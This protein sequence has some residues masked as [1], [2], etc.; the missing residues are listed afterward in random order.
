MGRVG[1]VGGGLF[2]RTAL[3]LERLLPDAR[4]VIIDHSAAHLSIAERLVGPEVQL[5]NETYEPARHDGFDL[6]VVPLSY[7]GDRERLYVDPP[8]GAVLIHDWLW[9][10]RSR[11]EVVSL[12]LLKRLNLIRRSDVKP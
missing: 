9:R 1:I 7:V 5:I 10:R 2:P 11:S 12:L 8:S 3:V 4:L 6:V